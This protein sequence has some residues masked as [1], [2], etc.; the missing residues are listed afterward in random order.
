MGEK[1][2]SVKDMVK[3]GKKCA[4]AY[5]KAGSLFYK[6]EEGFIFPVPAADVAEGVLSAEERAMTLMKWIKREVEA[7]SKETT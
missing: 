6:H 4:F 1:Q 7:Q 3:D 5:F 2:W